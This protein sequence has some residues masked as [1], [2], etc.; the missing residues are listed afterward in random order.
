M[1]GANAGA[2]VVAV[3]AGG[4]GLSARNDQHHDNQG[5]GLWL[6][7]LDGSQQSASLVQLTG[8]TQPQRQLQGA[9][10]CT[11]TKGTLGT[12]T[13]GG[14]HVTLR[15]QAGQVPLQKCKTHVHTVVKQMHVHTVQWCGR[16]VGSTAYTQPPAAHFK[17]H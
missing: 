9:V 17:G 13:F 6:R 7:H 8:A 12:N 15:K 11:C 10:K 4:A 1:R 3:V 16:V 14:G 2:S 5:A